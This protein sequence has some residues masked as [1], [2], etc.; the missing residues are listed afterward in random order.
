MMNQLEEQC[1]PY[2]S[3][4]YTPIVYIDGLKLAEQAVMLS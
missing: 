2:E 4:L 1:I 3:S